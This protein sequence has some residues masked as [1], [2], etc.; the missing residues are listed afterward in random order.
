MKYAELN[1]KGNWVKC[2]AQALDASY[3]HFLCRCPECHAQ[4]FLCIS[5]KGCENYFR[6]NLHALKCGIAVGGIVIKDP[7][8]REF[9]LEDAFKHI[10]KPYVA[11]PA[12]QQMNN[13]DSDFDIDDYI[14]E[15]VDNMTIR[16]KKKLRQCSSMFNAIEQMK[17]DDH[18]LPNLLVKDFIIDA[19]TIEDA[20]KTT[21]QGRKMIVATRFNINSLNPPISRP[22][23][24]VCLRDAYTKD[25]FKAIYYLLSF[26]EPT[27]D[28]HFRDLIF[29]NKRE[30]IPKDPHKYIVAMGT[31]TPFYDPH[32]TMYVVEPLSSARFCM[33]NRKDP[34]HE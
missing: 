20:R 16:E 23:E 12:K 11:A 15:P 25:D 8:G 18:I 26:A 1:V 19:R 17:T 34:F 24:Y 2:D 27:R 4:A 5:H 6:S 7:S 33:T 22:S 30:N 10:D 21:L 28:K 3:K 29:G 31:L 32:Y 13:F 9:R 14:A